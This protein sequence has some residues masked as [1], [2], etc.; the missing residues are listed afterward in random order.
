MM[1]KLFSLMLLLATMFALTGCSSGDEVWGLRIGQSRKSVAEQLKDR[2]YRVENFSDD[3]YI[4]VDEKVEYQGI[5]WD[6]V[7]CWFDDNNKLKSVQFDTYGPR[8]D[9]QIEKLGKYIKEEGYPELK[10][11]ERCPGFYMSDKLPMTVMLSL[12][13]GQYGSVTLHYCKDA[14]KGE[15]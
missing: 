2:G 15:K 14:H 7:T 8:P 11:A 6:A 3:S 13:K 12:P 1:K 9:Y 10:E 5:T 4:S